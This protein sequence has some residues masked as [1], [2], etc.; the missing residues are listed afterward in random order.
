M[1]NSKKL[2]CNITGPYDVVASAL[3]SIAAGRGFDSI[4]GWIAFHDAQL[5]GSELTQRV[6][7]GAGLIGW[8][9]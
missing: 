2:I 4:S 3:T 5:C 9:G 8:G 6:L 7:L 1:H